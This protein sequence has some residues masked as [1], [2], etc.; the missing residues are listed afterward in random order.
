M[1]PVSKALEVTAASRYDAYSAVTNNLVF[2]PSNGKLL[3][4]A[5][6]G[7]ANKK[8]T[9]KLAF[10]F[11]PVDNLLVRGS[12]GTG[13]KVANMDSI[14]S[15]IRQAGNTSG[16]YPCPVKAPD[17]RAAYCTGTTQQYLL[18]GGNNLKGPSGLK[19]ET[20]KQYTIGLRFD[21]VTNLSLGLDLW[22]V[23]MKDQIT[24]LPEQFPFADPVKFNNNFSIVYD[25]G[26]G[27]NKLVTLL[28]TFN[29]A[30]ARYQGIDWDNTYATKTAFGKLNLKWSGTLMLQ[31]EVDVPG[32]PTESSL[33]RFDA[34]NNATSR[35]ISHISASLNSKDMYTNTLMMNYRSGYQDQVL[36]ANDNALKL[37]NSDGSLPVEFTGLKR[38]VRAFITFDWQTRVQFKEYNNLTLSLGIRN[39][40]DKA[41][42]LSIRIAGGGN[43]AGYDA[44]YAN[45]LGRQFYI[46]GGL[47]F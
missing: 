21:P 43:Q 30:A 33:G 7:N 6:Q 27:S 17:P 8:A 14:T 29:L 38:D 11:N 1:I 35:V 25:Q 9:Y 13:F 4:P 42:P 32:S 31:S 16:S 2:D 37:V 46:N 24:S 47:S 12:Y 34:Y 23:K 18:S 22:S 28:P 39:L 26:I 36:T 5:E 20:S 45:P 10:R 40:F 41:P 44:R 3:P 19:P 15:P